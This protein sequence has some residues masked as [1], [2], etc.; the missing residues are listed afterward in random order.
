LTD[1]KKVSGGNSSALA[2][3]ELAFILK[4]E[5]QTYT[6]RVPLFKKMVLE[7]EPDILLE[8]ELKHL[9]DH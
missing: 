4:R 7:Q 6:F 9:Q 2:R 5:K 1:E 8:G 3:L